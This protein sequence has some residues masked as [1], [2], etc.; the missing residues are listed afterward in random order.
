M[1]INIP[2][3]KLFFRSLRTLAYESSALPPF[4]VGSMMQGGDRTFFSWWGDVV[5]VGW[6]VVRDGFHPVLCTQRSS[7]GK[8]WLRERFLNVLTS[9]HWCSTKRC[10]CFF[11]RLQIFRIVLRMLAHFWSPPI[12]AINKSMVCTYLATRRNIST[13]SAAYQLHFRYRILRIPEPILSQMVRHIVF[14]LRNQKYSVTFLWQIR[15]TILVGSI[16]CTLIV[17]YIF[18][19]FVQIC[20]LHYKSVSPKM[21]AAVRPTISCGLS[22]Q[23]LNL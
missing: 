23:M 21:W 10:F 15:T 17:F 20:R 19:H 11:L 5:F 7:D 16:K 22:C 14:Q 13:W 8:E 9:G 4:E 18:C 6:Y 2:C 12:C 1:K 3:I